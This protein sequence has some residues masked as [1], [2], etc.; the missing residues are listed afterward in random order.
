MS[1]FQGMSSAN[2][3][4]SEGQ[5]RPCLCCHREPPMEEGTQGLQY[6]SHFTEGNADPLTRDTP[7]GGRQLRARPACV[8]PYVTTGVRR[9]GWGASSGA[10]SPPPPPRVLAVMQ[11]T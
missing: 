4:L 9:V 10:G 5:V 7:A 6:C 11:E 8:T 2:S 1:T 3:S